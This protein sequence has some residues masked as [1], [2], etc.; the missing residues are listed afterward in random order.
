MR[1]TLTIVVLLLGFAG[2]LA[3]VLTNASG[4][5]A[6]T[7]GTASPQASVGQPDPGNDPGGDVRSEPAATGEPGDGDPEPTSPGPGPD[8]Q[9]PRATTPDPQD[10]PTEPEPTES[11]GPV[12]PAR[13]PLQVGV[14]HTQDTIEPWDPAQAQKVARRVLRRSAPWQN[15]YLMGWGAVNPEPRPGTFDWTSL[16]IRMSLIAETGGEPI[17]TLCCA[18]DWMKGGKPGQ[19]DWDDLGLPPEPKHFDDFADL[20]A[21]VAKR[22]PQ[23]RH[24]VVW[25]EMRGFFDERANTWDAPAYTK[26]YNKVYRALKR[27]NPDIKVGGPYTVMDSWLDPVH[28]TAP[29]PIRGGWGVL[30]HRVIEVIDYWLEHSVGADFLAVNGTS[31]NRETGPVRPVTIAIQKFADVTTALRER[32]DLPIWWME[33]FSPAAD[34]RPSTYSNWIPATRESIDDAF[35]A[36]EASGAELALLWD[37]QGR[38]VRRCTNCLWTYPGSPGGSKATTFANLMKEWAARSR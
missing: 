23:V 34:R 5:E 28:M 14:T 22:Y 6:V 37:P 2:A 19:T 4:G 10:D 35:S 21:A 29:S 9:E 26:L 27:V 31:S 36:L 17:I 32:T 13:A 38:S 33:V 16:D 15:Q 24:Y 8:S 30:D 3:L 12:E 1:R 25:S 7:G 20:A 18:P 11:D